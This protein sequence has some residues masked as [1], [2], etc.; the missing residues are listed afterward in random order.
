[1][2]ET[3]WADTLFQC[4]ECVFIV[5]TICHCAA[6][7]YYMSARESSQ[8]EEESEEEEEDE[9]EE[10]AEE[11]GYTNLSKLTLSHFS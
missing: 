5:S 1:M 2:S 3:A 4:K 9:E 7:N 8:E 10:E 6:E 11:H